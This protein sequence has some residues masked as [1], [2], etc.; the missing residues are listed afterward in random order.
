MLHRQRAVSPPPQPRPSF[1]R[2]G[3]PGRAMLAMIASAVTAAFHPAEAQGGGFGTIAGVAADSL[4]VSPL[5]GALVSVVG[6]GRSAVTDEEGL[7]AI[8]SVPAGSVRLA[9]FHPLLDTVGISLVSELLVVTSDSTL[10]VVVAVP[11][12]LTV[13]RLKCGSDAASAILGSVARADDPAPP[14]AAFV[15]LSWTEVQVGRGIGVRQTPR[16][17]T[18]PVAADGTFRLCSIPADV[19]GELVAYAGAD[20][21]AA[22]PASMGEGPA[23]ALVGLTLPG[24]DVERVTMEPEA[25]VDADETVVPSGPGATSGTMLRG[26]AVIQGRVVDSTGRAVAGARVALQGAVG[27]ATTDSMG[28][29]TLANQPSGSGILITRKL[30]FPM[31]ETPVSMTATGLNEVTVRM[32]SGSVTVLSEVIV[33]ANRQMALERVGFFRRQQGRRGNLYLDVDQMDAMANR[34]SLANVLAGA[35]NLTYRSGRIAGRP[36][37][38]RVT[39]GADR[40]VGLSGTY[41]C[42]AYIVDGRIWPPNTGDPTEFMM[43][44]EIAAIEVYRAGDVPQTVPDW[45]YARNCETIVIWTRFHIARGG[46]RRSR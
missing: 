2:L 16:E 36:R 18:A 27:A 7:F 20:T 23:L 14:A 37:A 26:G 4:H 40:D 22:L 34:P 35:S 12:A 33:Q 42:V 32:E 44:S 25:G 6:I 3:L 19:Y 11:S 46:T 9:V 8:D 28:A 10:N 1:S 17:M 29:F 15:R 5:A 45:L 41:T 13:L 38:G 30:G 31:T 43:P 21:S 24:A 39:V